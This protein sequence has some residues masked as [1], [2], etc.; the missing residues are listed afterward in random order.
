L[1]RRKGVVSSG[2]GG[3]C[4][5]ATKGAAKGMEEES[6]ICPTME[7]AGALWRGHSG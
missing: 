5:Q 1:E 7:G 6:G 3:V 2:R 4:G